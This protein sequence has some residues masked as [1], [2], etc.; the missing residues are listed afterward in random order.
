MPPK[1][2]WGPAM[3]LYRVLVAIRQLLA[4][5]N[6]RDP[7]EVAIAEEYVSQPE[8]FKAKARQQVARYATPQAATPATAAAVAS[9]GVQGIHAAAV[10]DK[11][12]GQ[13]TGSKEEQQ[14]QQAQAQGEQPLRQQQQQQDQT[15]LQ[16]QQQALQAAAGA[17]TEV[18]GE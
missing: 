3:D 8:V 16:H 4:E 5:P 2:S 11:E 18:G 15:S 17:V 6:P 13:Q 12:H 9:Q 7:L 1:G 14:Q 10:G